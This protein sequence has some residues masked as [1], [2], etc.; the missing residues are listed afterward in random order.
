MHEY[1]KKK[2]DKL[3]LSNFE[4]EKN[5]KYENA[6][7]NIVEFVKEKQIIY[8]RKIGPLPHRKNRKLYTGLYATLSCVN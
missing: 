2:V 3:R 6:K 7:I 5:T 4:A 1:P 8:K